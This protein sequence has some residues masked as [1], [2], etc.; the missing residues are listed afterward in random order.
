MSVSLKTFLP[1]AVSEN[2]EML[3]KLAPRLTAVTER[4]KKNYFYCWI[5]LVLRVQRG[6]VENDLVT[7]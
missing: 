3:S 2:V 4:G 7:S 6:I 1:F 5:L